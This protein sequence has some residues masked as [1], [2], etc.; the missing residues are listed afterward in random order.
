MDIDISLEGHIGVISIQRPPNNHF[1]H[2]L[3]SD[4][5]DSLEDFDKEIECRCIVLCSEGKH[6]CAGAN[7]DQDRDMKDKKDPYSELYK[8]AV[9]LFKTNKP[10]V[11]AVQ[12]GAIGGGLGLSL[13]GDF[14]V[15]C[16]ES[17]FSANFS[18]LGFH[19]GFGLSLIHI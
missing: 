18:M 7:F 8:Q 1:D 15:G 2:Q 14:R 13:V 16:P 3:I 12:G 11:V 6:F 17:R 19:Q 4:I 5:A 9:R 10:I